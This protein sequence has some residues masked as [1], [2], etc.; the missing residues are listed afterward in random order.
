MRTFL[1]FLVSNNM[2]QWPLILNRQAELPEHTVYPPQSVHP[3]E[4]GD[5]DVQETRQKHTADYHQKHD[6]TFKYQFKYSFAVVF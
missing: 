3:G 4:P 2:S 5:T 1:I 6:V